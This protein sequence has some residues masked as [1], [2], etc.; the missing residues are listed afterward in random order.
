MTN[1]SIASQTQGQLTVGL[2]LGDRFSQLCVLDDTPEVVEEARV[3]TSAEG[4][5]RR[6]EAME[7]CLVALEAGTHSPWVSRLLVA[8]GHECL[9]ANPT[10]LYRRGQNKNDRVDAEKLARWARSDPQLL[11]PITH[12]TEDMQADLALLYG[13]RSLVEAR[14]KL[15]N[16]VR[17]LVKAYGTRLPDCDARSFP[18]KVRDVVPQALRPAMDPLLRSTEQ[19]SSEIDA[20]DRRVDQLAESKYGPQTGAMRQITGVGPLTSTAF[21]LVIRDPYRF[22]RS[23]EVGPYI[24]LTPRQDQSGQSDPELGISKAGNEYLRQLLVGCAHYIMGPF[25]PD[26]DLRRW[27]LRKAQGG[28][29]AKKRAVVAVARKLAV[30]MHRLWLT[31]EI[32]EPL[33]EDTITPVNKA[34]THGSLRAQD[35]VPSEGGPA[36]QPD[37]AL[38]SPLNPVSEVQ[39]DR[40]TKGN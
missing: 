39:K 15:I 18:T 13:R 12:R 34:A 21:V 37:A 30:L 6:F 36:M 29:N 14:T 38:L 32:Y 1:L 11:K 8:L 19:L 28:N 33:R 31:G 7:P 5:R 4:L 9:V 35:G 24:G 26:C 25:G 27:G 10:A 3:R 23:R 22:R 40:Q 16:T 17:G 20:L 2:D